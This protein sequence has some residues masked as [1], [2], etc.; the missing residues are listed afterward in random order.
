MPLA[1]SLGGAHAFIDL[2]RSAPAKPTLA[3]MK[4]LGVGVPEPTS[5]PKPSGLKKR[6]QG[7]NTCGFVD[8][9]RG[10]YHP[11]GGGLGLHHA[12]YIHV[13]NPRDSKCCYVRG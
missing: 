6:A 4:A 3:A 10:E 13:A 9:D 2:A 12:C 1:L 5:P 7:A 8:G 11:P